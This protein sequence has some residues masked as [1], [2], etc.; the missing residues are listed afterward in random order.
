MAKDIYKKPGRCP[1]EYWNNPLRAA[2][3][4]EL[5]QA[6]VQVLYQ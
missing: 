2:S 5:L 4:K 3:K 1:D 6:D